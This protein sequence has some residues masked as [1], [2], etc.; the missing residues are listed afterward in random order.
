MEYIHRT[1]QCLDLIPNFNFHPKCDKLK[2]TNF[3]FADDLLLF[4]RDGVESIKLMMN[5]FRE[6]SAASG[7]KASIPK[8]KIYYGGV[9]NTTKLQINK[10]T[11]FDTGSMP[12]KYLG[13][14]LA[15]GNYQLLCANL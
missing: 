3:C 12:F 7:L 6:L 5:K 4:V 14:P 2:I 11:G 8:C 13:V 10:E 1:M 15:V 9:D